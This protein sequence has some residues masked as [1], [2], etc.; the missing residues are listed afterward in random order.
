M[1][2]R[3][4]AQTNE[5]L[6]VAPRRHMKKTIARKGFAR[7]ISSPTSRSA[8]FQAKELTPSC[9][10]AKGSAGLARRRRTEKKKTCFVELAAVFRAISAGFLGRNDAGEGETRR[11]ELFGA[12]KG[13]SWAGPPVNGGGEGMGRE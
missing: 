8:G 6:A 7:W 13:R 10:G 5:N 4:A 3:G 1:S 12:G 2:S 11:G 9:G